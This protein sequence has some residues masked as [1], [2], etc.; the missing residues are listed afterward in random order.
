MPKSKKTYKKGGLSSLYAMKEIAKK[1]GNMKQYK[2]L[3]RKVK[4]AE[5]KK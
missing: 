2:A 3:D 4:K 1:K 5:G